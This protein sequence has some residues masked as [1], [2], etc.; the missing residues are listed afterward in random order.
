ML[1]AGSQLMGLY[2]M[3]A[4]V[5]QPWYFT[6]LAP[7][8]T[9]TVA[10]GEKGR[11]F[12]INSALAWLWLGGA[13]I[14]TDLSYLPNGADSWPGIRLFEYVPFYALLAWAALNAWGRRRAGGVGA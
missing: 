11:P 2:L 9:L 1:I 4:P 10:P 6:W 5:V 8:V 3:V 14:L 13:S 7:L 12:A